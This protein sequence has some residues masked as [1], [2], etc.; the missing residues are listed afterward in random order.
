M[1]NYLPLAFLLIPFITAAQVGFIDS[2]FGSNGIVFPSD[3]LFKGRMESYDAM[4]LQPDGKI[5]LAGVA[6][7]SEPPYSDVAVMRLRANGQCD[8][9]FGDG[10]LVRSDVDNGFQTGRGI[11]L[12]PD[13]KILVGGYFTSY[14]GAGVNRITRLNA[15]GTPDATF[16]PGG[17]RFLHIF[18][19]A[20]T[21]S[22]PIGTSQKPPAHAS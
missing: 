3:G 20:A 8:P 15:D 16:N 1:K 14:N 17:L 10:G 2:T 5:L 9:F 4:T 19:F 11:A 18:T 12:Q 13:G 7:N 6:W 22:K 21:P